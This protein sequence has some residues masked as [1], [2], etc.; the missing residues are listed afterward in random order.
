VAAAARDEWPGNDIPTF[1]NNPEACAQLDRLVKRIYPD[2]KLPNFDKEVIHQHI[3]DCLN[4]RRRNIKKG[5]D[6]EQ[7]QVVHI[8]ASTSFGY[9]NHIYFMLY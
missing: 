5:Y 8:M 4:E 6:Y 1:R 3:R 9:T 2:C 7:V